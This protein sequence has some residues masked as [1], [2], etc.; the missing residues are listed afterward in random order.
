MIILYVGNSPEEFEPIAN[1]KSIIFNAVSN[2]IEAI[3]FIKRNDDID[4]VI[5]EYKL[6]GNS[7]LFFYD[8]LNNGNDYKKIPFI[9]LS[10]EYNAKLFT[11]AFNKGINDYFVSASTDKQQIIERAQSLYNMQCLKI[12][13]LSNKVNDQSYKLPLSKRL[14]D[15]VFASLVLIGIAPLMLLTMLAIRLESKGKVY[16]IAKRVGRQ[17]FDFYKLR[18]MRTGSD[19]MIKDLAKKNNQYKK[20]TEEKTI[21]FN[22]PCPECSKLDDGSFCSPVLY[23]NENEICD[24]W[25]SQQKKDIETKNSTFIKI[26]DDPRITRVGKFIRNTSI[27]ELPQLINVIKGDMSIVGNRPLPVYEAELLTKDAMSKRFLAP[28]GITGLWQVELRGRGGNMS[29]EERM[30]L[31]NEYVDNFTGNRYSFWYDMKLILRT[32]PGL[33]QKSTV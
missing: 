24:N 11:T 23:I 4:V 9:L 15:I 33:I 25:Y 14:F 7:G 21:N 16:Y 3:N 10:E 8:E 5:C 30:R 22:A 20:D 17:T 6:P 13:G 28:A 27:D 12:D 32:F 2:S 19:Q 31:D 1:D 29:E 26:L 18:S